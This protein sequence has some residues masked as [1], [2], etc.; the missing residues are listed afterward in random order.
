MKKLFIVLIASCVA[1]LTYSQ[2]KKE[3]KVWARVDALQKAVFETKDSMVMKDLVSE[4]LTYGHSGGNIE[5]KA[6]MVRNASNS[7]TVYKNSTVERLGINVRKKTAYVRYIFRTTSID[8]GVASPLDLGL[9]QV[10]QKEHGKWMLE[11]RQAVKVKPK[12]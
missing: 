4:T 2:S 1:T 10:W 9:L 6:T 7:K 12:Q 5:D 3:A 11:A 8:N